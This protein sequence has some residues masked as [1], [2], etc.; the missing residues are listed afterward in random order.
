MKL[1]FRFCYG[2]VIFTIL[3]LQAATANHIIPL[4]FS[5]LLIN[6]CL[7]LFGFFGIAQAYMAQQQGL[8]TQ[9]AF[10]FMSILILIYALVQMAL[11]II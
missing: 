6:L 10:L 2:G 7:C 11:T 8:S 3:V 4:D 9:K 5:T 1:A